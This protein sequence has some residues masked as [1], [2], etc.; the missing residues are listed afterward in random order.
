M[1]RVAVVVRGRSIRVNGSGLGLRPFREML[2][3]LHDR[4]C[5]RP[6]HSRPL[7]AEALDVDDWK[8]SVFCSMG[9]TT[10][11]KTLNVCRSNCGL[12]GDWG[13]AFS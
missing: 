11:R 8:L 9:F 13:P 1:I 6:V 3:T 12:G 2:A 5:V 10:L 7:P 4:R